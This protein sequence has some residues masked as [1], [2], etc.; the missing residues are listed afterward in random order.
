MLILKR[1]GAVFAGFFLIGLLG[2][3]TDTVL[4][5]FG[6]LPIPTKHKFETRH[7]LL[8]L[9]Y[10]ILFVVLG[11]FVTA[12][13]A[14]DRPLA[15]GDNPG[16]SWYNDQ[17]AGPHRNYHA[18]YCSSVVWMVANY[19]FCSSLMVRWEAGGP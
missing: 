7:A 13:L 10:H 18:G 1:V 14:P 12:R 2:F 11:S 16:Y 4:Q 15:H 19:L 9:S 5:Q 8:A 17:H 6:V 3:V